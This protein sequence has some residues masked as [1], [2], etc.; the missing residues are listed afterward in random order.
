MPIKPLDRRK[1]LSFMI[2]AA[3]VAPTACGKKDTADDP[4]ATGSTSSGVASTGSSSGSTVGTLTVGA[5][6][7]ALPD[8]ETMFKASISSL[9]LAPSG[10]P[11]VVPDIAADVSTYLTGDVSTLVADL[12]AAVS[13]HNWASARTLMDSFHQAQAK[14]RVIQDTARQVQ[15]LSDMTGST[16]RMKKIGAK[17]A[18]G[19][20]IIAGTDPG[21]GNF[22]AAA[23]KAV[24]R[25]IDLKPST[26]VPGAP[27]VGA[28]GMKSL[29]FHIAGKETASNV[30]KAKLTFCSAA[31]KAL[32]A[33]LIT[34]DGTANS[35]SYESS[36]SD[37][38]TIGAATLTRSRHALVSGVLAADGAGSTT[39]DSDSARTV[40][41]ENKNELGDS[42]TQ[43]FNARID[44]T[45]SS[46]STT[47]IGQDEVVVLGQSAVSSRKG[48]AMTTFTGDKAANVAVS[49]GAG[50]Q[51]GSFT[52]GT[53][54]AQSIA[55]ALGFEYQADALP[56]YTTVESSTLL[57]AVNA[58]DFETDAILKQSAPA[59]PDLALVSDDDCDVT[60]AVATAIVSLASPTLA[61]AVKECETKFVKM[62]EICKAVD[63]KERDVFAALQADR[64]A[65]P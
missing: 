60:E 63:A 8:L 16:C 51:S 21:D 55:E 44:I 45:G 28:D 46:L 7:N 19:I 62:D 40:L 48:L 2:V 6:L 25:V 29:V 20:K 5:G 3:L 47:F 54:A 13:A 65:H 56:R 32:G 14:C 27:K 64:A 10:T 11:P 1:P 23:D 18:G 15:D 37:S 38:L 17:G 52:V 4:A 34:V 39:F 26:Q 50:K 43:T 22:F 31:G 41:V 59:D 42:A 12:Q 36:H 53:A 57:D 58:V 30:Y 35:L 61:D 49:E 33:E 24:V 9:G